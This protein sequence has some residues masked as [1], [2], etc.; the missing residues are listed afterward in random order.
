MKF[1]QNNQSIGLLIFL[2]VMPVVIILIPMDDYGRLGNPFLVAVFVDIVLYLVY[3]TVCW[4]VYLDQQTLRF[5]NNWMFYWINKHK[6]W[7]EQIEEVE[8]IYGSPYNIVRVYMDGY[9]RRFSSIGDKSAKQ[10]VEDLKALDVKV[11]ENK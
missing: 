5:R 7:L 9:S 4:N 8:I 2:F 10:L 11:V 1:Y 6:F 3:A